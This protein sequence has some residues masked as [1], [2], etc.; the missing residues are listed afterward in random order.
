LRVFTRAGRQSFDSNRSTSVTLDNELQKCLVDPIKTKVVDL[1][2]PRRF[3]NNPL[4][5]RGVTVHLRK[6][7]DATQ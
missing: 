2:R 3:L 1:Q 7:S 6:I 5:N 4:S